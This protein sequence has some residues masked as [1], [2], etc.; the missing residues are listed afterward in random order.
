L[1]FAIFRRQESGPLTKA[2][3]KPSLEREFARAA[4]ENGLVA[5][6]MLDI[7]HFKRF[8]DLHGHDAGDA[9]LRQVGQTLMQSCR[10]AD[11]ACR[12]GGEEF[13]VV[14]PGA[15]GHAARD[16]SERFLERIRSLE[17][18]LRGTILPRLT[19]S[20]GIAL[21]PEHGAEA[22][23]VLRAADFALYDA[24]HAGRDRC[25]VSGDPETKTTAGV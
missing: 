14:L 2:V 25:M 7:D 16:W 18:S 4:R 10:A 24:K 21:Y 3:P 19:I 17:I 11:L 1:T 12:F 9:A 8:N 22:D 20:I 5:V 13:T 23:S 6:L 15:G